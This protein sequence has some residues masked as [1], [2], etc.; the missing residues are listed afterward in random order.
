MPTPLKSAG[1][2]TKDAPRACPRQASGD[3]P[4]STFVV[5]KHRGHPSHPPPTTTCSSKDTSDRRHTVRVSKCRENNVGSQECWASPSVC[6]D[7]GHA[8]VCRALYQ[9]FHSRDLMSSSP[10][11]A[12]TPQSRG[13]PRLS[14]WIQPYLRSPPKGMGCLF[15]LIKSDRK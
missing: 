12:R 6:D 7:S 14:G 9:E 11:S 1:A 13:G 5:E 8:I 15:L 2:G 4:K 3:Q 10:G